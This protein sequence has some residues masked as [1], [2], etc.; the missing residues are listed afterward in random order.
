MIKGC[1]RDSGTDADIAGA[2]GRICTHHRNRRADAVIA[3]MMIGEPDRV[4]TAAVHDFD[5]LQGASVDGG[6]GLASLRP[7]E[8]L[9]NSEFHLFFTHPETWRASFRSHQIVAVQLGETRASDLTHHEVDLAAQNLN[10]LL[11]PARARRRGANNVARPTK[12][13]R[14]PSAHATRI[15]APRLTPLSSMRTILSPTAA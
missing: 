7:T 11:Y 9:Q 12:T 3:E 14:A 1:E 2:G 8:K 6:Q 10:R 4:V 13:K 15:S 5:T